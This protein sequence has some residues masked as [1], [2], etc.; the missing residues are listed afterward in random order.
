MMGAGAAQ[1]G[2]AG[3]AAAAQLGTPNANV[4]AHR[5]PELLDGV[6]RALSHRRRPERARLAFTLRQPR[7][8]ILHG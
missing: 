4:Q 8:R 7:R 3:A 5:M 1:L 6:A 2:G